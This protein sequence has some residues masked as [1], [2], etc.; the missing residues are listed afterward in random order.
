MKTKNGTEVLEGA[1]RAVMRLSFEEYVRLALR[2]ESVPPR[3]A[4]GRL[5]GWGAL[6][7]AVFGG[8][9]LPNRQQVRIAHAT[10]GLST[11]LAELLEAAGRFPAE[12]T[13]QAGVGLREELGDLLWYCAIGIDAC[14]PDLKKHGALGKLMPQWEDPGKF[15][16]DLAD[17]SPL[18]AIM[19]LQLPTF[20]SRPAD[21]LKRS[22]YYGRPLDTYNIG[23][24]FCS[25]VVVIGNLAHHFG[26][27][28]PAVAAANIRKL[29]VRYPEKFTEEH[30]LDR[31]LNLELD[32]LEGR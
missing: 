16:I 19:V 22:L 2:T 1:G 23:T 21:L 14:L 6:A 28:L 9:S 10:L 13:L 25:L 7:M 31:R 11:E 5:S 26:T 15:A 12:R 4:V 24:A 8:N 18:A 27:T 30:A 3:L 20:C 29:H 17:A 32:A